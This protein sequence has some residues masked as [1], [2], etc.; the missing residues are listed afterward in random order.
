MPK[1][2][3]KSTHE[4]AKLMWGNGLSA[5]IPTTFSGGVITFASLLVIEIQ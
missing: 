5:S 1:T 2:T 3:S 4:A